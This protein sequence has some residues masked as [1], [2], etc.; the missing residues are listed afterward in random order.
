M[1]VPDVTLDRPFSSGFNSLVCGLFDVKRKVFPG[2]L[3]SL[4]VFRFG[5]ADDNEDVVDDWDDDWDDKD[6]LR[7]FSD[8]LLGCRARVF[9]VV[10][11]WLLWASAMLELLFVFLLELRCVAWG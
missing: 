7:D 6:D 9:G 1:S 4:A 2:F 11:C 8:D 5:D 10:D 3:D